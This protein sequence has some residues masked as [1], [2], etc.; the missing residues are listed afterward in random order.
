MKLSF[1]RLNTISDLPYYLIKSL[2]MTVFWLILAEMTT[3]QTLPSEASDAK[4]KVE[5][6]DRDRP[7]VQ[8]PI[9]VD[10]PYDSQNFLDRQQEGI[11]FLP[12]SES[13][14]ILEV[15]DEIER[16]VNDIETEEKS[17]VK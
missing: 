14:S 9:F 6:R 7:S 8:Q 3:A 17:Q 16:E 11:Y 15:D 5:H 12:E 13:D 2:L 1:I 4:P 10:P